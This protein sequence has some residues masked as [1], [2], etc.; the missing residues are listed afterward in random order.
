MSRSPVAIFGN[1]R[2]GRDMRVPSAIVGPLH[3]SREASRSGGRTPV[4]C[5]DQDRH[6]ARRTRQPAR[7]DE[8]MVGRKL[9][10]RWV[11]LNAIEYTRRRERRAGRLFPRRDDRERLRGPVVGGTEGRDYRWS[12]M[13]SRLHG[14]ERADI[15]HP[16]FWAQRKSAPFTRICPPHEKPSKSALVRRWRVSRFTVFSPPLDTAAPEASLLGPRG[17]GETLW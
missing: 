7:S 6:S 14:L 11:D 5:Q 9:W 1:G 8:R 3:E 15:R 16:E 12:G 17:C 10:C 13:T 4:S 2:S